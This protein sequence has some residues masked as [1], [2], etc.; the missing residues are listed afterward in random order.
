[1]LAS[2]TN[3]LPIANHHQ[4]LCP[5]VLLLTGLLATYH[6]LSVALS[7][8]VGGGGSGLHVANELLMPCIASTK[9]G[10]TVA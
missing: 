6:S 1:M 8:P 5:A 4:W 7:T 2:Y 9:K 10:V 3:P